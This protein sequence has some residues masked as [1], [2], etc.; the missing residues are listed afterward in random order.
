MALLEGSYMDRS[1]EAAEL[2]QRGVGGSNKTDSGIFVV[3]LY[4]YCTEPH[5]QFC[6]RVARFQQVTKQVDI[7]TLA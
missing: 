5:N 2:C 1:E 6:R 3:V 7:V 4:V